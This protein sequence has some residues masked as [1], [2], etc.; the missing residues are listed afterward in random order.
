MHGPPPRSAHHRRGPAPRARAGRHLPHRA[1]PPRRDGQVDALPA[2]GRHRQP[3]HRDALVAGRRARRAVQPAGRAA[4]AAGPGDPRRRGPA[5]AARSRRTS[6]A[7]C[8]PPAPR[9]ARRDIYVIELEPGEVR[10]AEAHIAGQRRAPRAW[11]PG[12]CGPGRPASRSSWRRATTSRSPA[13]CRTPT[14]RWSRAPGR[15]S[16]WSIRVTARDPRVQPGH[17]VLDVR[18]DD[19]TGRAAAPS[20][21]QRAPPPRRPVAESS[22][23]VTR[24]PSA[25][26]DRSAAPGSDERRRQR[27]VQVDDQPAAR[28]VPGVQRLDRAVVHHPAV[29]DHHQPPAE[30]L[31]V[32]QVVRGEHQRGV[33]RRRPARPG[34]TGPPACSPRPGRSSARPGTAPRGPCSS[35]AVSSPR[36]RWPSESCRTGVSRNASRSSSARQRRSRAAWSAAGTR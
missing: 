13:T 31:D 21:G 16:S 24:R 28:A 29:V 17:H 25:S 5:A 14:R 1:G 27:L 26:V 4:R 33:A 20:A 11:R 8:S 19:A 23:N 35:A 34:T 30:P 12:G 3:Q 9:H 2:R 6:P 22:A 18:L 36:I 7:P 32:G 15:C 10:E